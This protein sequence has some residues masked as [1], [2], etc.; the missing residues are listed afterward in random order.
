MK[1]F[2]RKHFHEFVDIYIIWSFFNFL[3]QLFNYYVIVNLNK[4]EAERREP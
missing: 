3:L 4:V 2:S 1:T